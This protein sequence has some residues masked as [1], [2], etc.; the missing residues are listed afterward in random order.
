MNGVKKK[1][2]I[3]KINQMNGVKKKYP[4]LKINQ[5]DYCGGFHFE[6]NFT[7]NFTQ[8]PKAADSHTKNCFFKPR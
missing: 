3:L 6:A 1:Y 5:M 2:P 8:Q 4:I 7:Q